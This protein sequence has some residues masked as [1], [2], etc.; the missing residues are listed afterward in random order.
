MNNTLNQYLISLSGSTSILHE[1]RESLKDENFIMPS[2][3]QS[4]L[5]VGYTSSNLFINIMADDM[6]VNYFRNLAKMYKVPFA[7]YC[8]NELMRYY[9]RGYGND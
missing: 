5:S 6:P 8:E 3:D 4:I 7:V 9:N 1:I 2:Q